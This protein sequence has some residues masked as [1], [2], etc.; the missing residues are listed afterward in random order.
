M[1]IKVGENQA[2]GRLIL[3]APNVHGGGGGVLLSAILGDLP[4]DV[5]IIIQVDSRFSQSNVTNPQL[6]TRSLSPTILRRFFAEVWLFRNVGCDDIVLCFGNLPPLFKLSGSVS[7]FLQN[8]LLIDSSSLKGF[9]IAAKCRIFFERLW[10]RA[11]LNNCD[12]II[13]Q[14]KSMHSQ[15]KDRFLSKLPI[16]QLPFYKNFKGASVLLPAKT[17]RECDFIYVASGD[18]HKNHEILIEAWKELALEGLFP[19][20]RLTIDSQSCPKLLYQLRAAVEV[21]GARI[22]CLGSLTH[23]QVL[24]ELQKSRALIYP[25]LNESFGIPMLE[26]RQLGL[27]ILAPELDYVR[28]IL[29][30]DESF[31]AS[32]AIS[33]ARSVKRYLKIQESRK[34]ILMPSEFLKE[35]FNAKI[36]VTQ[37]GKM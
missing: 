16:R 28:D 17:D 12:E 36:E 30:P 6:T 14:T 18:P 33:V 24:N 19:L 15:V 5:K 10:L 23:N 34:T 2:M 13:V 25:S 27:G 35:I 31:D 7:L 29:D 20:L 37:K 9:S 1:Q 32:S 26:A 22:E 4:P 21:Y 8:K 11:C 3:H